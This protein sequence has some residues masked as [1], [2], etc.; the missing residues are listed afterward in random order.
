MLEPIPMTRVVST[1]AALDDARL[2][3]GAALLRTAA[4]EAL[5]VGADELALDDPHA[6]VV[7]DAGWCG[8]RMTRADAEQL[9]RAH[10]RWELPSS[11]TGLSQGRIGN[12]PVKLWVDGDDALLLVPHVAA[13]DLAELMAR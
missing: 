9:L 3:G 11:A 5:L 4:D 8:A 12:A 13:R 1:P 6:L 7:P 2:S 10:G